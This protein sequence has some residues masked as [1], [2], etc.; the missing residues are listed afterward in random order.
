M[1][2]GKILE[3]TILIVPQKIAN[4]GKKPDSLSPSEIEKVSLAAIQLALTSVT[5]EAEVTYIGGQKFPDITVK[6]NGR[7][8]GIEIK[9]TRT[10]VNPWTVPGG[11]IREGNRVDGVE[12]VWLLFTKL[13]KKVETR[14]RPYSEAVCDLAVTHSPRY[15]LSMESGKEESLFNRLGVS[16]DSVRASD[17]PFDFFRSYL[18][19]KA[20]ESGG[21]PW[22]SEKELETAVPPYIRLWEDIDDGKEIHLLVEAWALFAEDILFGESHNKY[23]RLALHLLRN[24]SIISTSLRDKFSAG[25]QREVQA[26]PGLYPAAFANFAEMLGEIRTKVKAGEIEGC[27]PWVKWK[28]NLLY[29]AQKSLDNA[30]EKNFMTKKSDK[31]NLKET[32][33]NMLKTIN[34]KKRLFQ[35]LKNLFRK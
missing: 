17:K 13:A 5:P 28:K 14:A 21:T 16:Y 7:T 23:K 27:E 2:L 35:L 22:W 32:T 9:S 1:N 24:H 3:K 11:S 8:N 33:K 34:E 4:S 26:N 15:I 25:G 20:K 18:E 10:A 6:H 19:K 30:T 12:D 29:A 31:E